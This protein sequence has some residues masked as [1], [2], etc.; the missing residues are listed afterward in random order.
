[1]PVSSYHS[2]RAVEKENVARATI[3]CANGQCH[4]SSE[5]VPRATIDCV[6]G[7]CHESSDILPRATIECTGGLCHESSEVVARASIDCVGGKCHES[8]EI[9]PRA[10]VQCT[11]G[12]CFESSSVIAR[13]AD[14]DSNNTFSPLT[15]NLLIALV[16]LFVVGICLLGAL[17]GLRARRRTQRRQ[18]DDMPFQA[19]PRPAS[20]FSTHTILTIATG[21]FARQSE[22][23]PINEKEILIEK[24]SFES[25]IDRAI[26][27]IRITLP[28]EM[29]ESG[30]RRS[31][32]VVKVSISEAGGVGFEPYNDERL[33][34]YQKADSAEF[35][36]V[37]LE[38][39]GGL[40]ESKKF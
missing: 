38:R 17:L 27:E 19:S 9:V 34:P 25:P 8:S 32:H 16:V 35:Q 3:E 30:K 23:S 12:H 31:G 26:P 22:T 24:E 18:T 1:M 14:T 37:D 15:M 21:P 28:E 13:R 6:G 33:P 29:D 40:K 5:I 10:L 2:L 20:R 4:E 11:D 36:F 7:Q 39:I